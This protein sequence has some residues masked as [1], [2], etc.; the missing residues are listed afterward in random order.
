MGLVHLGTSFQVSF[1]RAELP[2]SSLLALKSSFSLILSCNIIY[3]P[4]RDSGTVC[5]THPQNTMAP[6]SDVSEGLYGGRMSTEVNPKLVNLKGPGIFWIGSKIKK[7]DLLSWSTLLKWYDTDALP[8]LTNIDGIESAVRLTAKDQ[9]EEWPSLVLFVM[10]D[11]ALMRSGVIEQEL[12]RSTGFL[13]GGSR[14]YDHADFDCRFY[15]VISSCESS[16]EKTMGKLLG[17]R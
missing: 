7:P 6:N 3:R 12:D 11:L 17:A 4:Y 10:Q 9:S 2:A 1:L 8:A 13:P 5:E 14:Y 16:Q 15:N